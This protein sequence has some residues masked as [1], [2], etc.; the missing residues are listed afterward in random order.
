MTLTILFY[1]Y[2]PFLDLLLLLL[3]LIIC[4]RI[5]YIINSL[6]IYIIPTRF[7]EFKNWI[8]IK[9]LAKYDYDYSINILRR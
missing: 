1:C 7:W 4:I 8:K 9:Q 5:L 2:P 3:F 6:I